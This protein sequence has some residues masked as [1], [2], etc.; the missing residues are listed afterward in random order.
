[1][2]AYGAW[3]YSSIHFNLRLSVKVSY[4]LP[5]PSVLPPAFTEKEARGREWFLQAVWLIWGREELNCD[6]LILHPSAQS[7]YQMSYLYYVY[8]PKQ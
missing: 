7:L 6:P 4:Q 8:N 1:M 5:I 3:S 2:K